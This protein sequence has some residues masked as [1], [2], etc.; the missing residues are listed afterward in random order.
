M[1]PIRTILI[2]LAL[3]DLAGMGALWYGSLAMQNEKQNEVNLRRE[4]L[5]EDQNN[6]RLLA[7][8]RVLQAT[9]SDR[10]ALSKFLFKQ[11]DVDQIK[12]IS[13]IER[14]GTSTSGAVV[15]TISL[16]NAK[17]TV[18]SGD[19]S[20]KGT[21]PQI[22]H[23]LRLIE[24]Y[25]ARIVVTRLEAKSSGNAWTGSIKLDLLSVKPIPQAPATPKK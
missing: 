20:V 17:P 21:W 15:E 4:S 14:L 12:F 23:V 22:F 7:Q 18:L 6:T 5:A 3:F 25:P 13:S 1:K 24:E 8:K 2:T 9:E 16:D 11:N 10:L 19:F